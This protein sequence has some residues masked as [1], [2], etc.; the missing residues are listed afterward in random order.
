MHVVIVIFHVK[1]CWTSAITY[2]FYIF[3]SDVYHDY[4]INGRMS[5]YYLYFSIEMSNYKHNPFII[6]SSYNIKSIWMSLIIYTY[7]YTYMNT[8][9]EN[10]FCRLERGHDLRRPVYFAKDL[11]KHPTTVAHLCQGPVNRGCVQ[12][13]V[14]NSVFYL[15]N[16]QLKL[17]LLYVEQ[18]KS[19]PCTWQNLQ[20]VD[21]VVFFMKIGK[22]RWQ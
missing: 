16:S 5:S 21:S 11:C 7:T 10:Q 18:L 19:V 20:S 3:I 8:T 2:G 4:T 22:E 12:H 17:L 14:F 13:L 1:R 15:T 9:T 6:I